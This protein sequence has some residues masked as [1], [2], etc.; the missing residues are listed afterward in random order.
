MMATPSSRHQEVERRAVRQLA[1]FLV[2][3]RCKVYSG[4]VWCPAVSSGTV[5]SR[6][7][8]D[9]IV[10]PDISVVCD[11]GK[12]DKRGCKGAPDLIIEILSPPPGG[13]TGL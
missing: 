2:G 5:T 9:T 12:I 11:R 1:N 8:F 7:M 13:M 3:K 10:E 4:P 6:K